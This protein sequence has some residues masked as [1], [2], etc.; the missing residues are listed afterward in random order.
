MCD[1]FAASNYRQL[2]VS[3]SRAP[4]S[5]EGYH[6]WHAV[7]GI[8][9]PA[10]L[11]TLALSGPRSTSCGTRTWSLTRRQPIPICLTLLPFQLHVTVLYSTAV[12]ASC[13]ETSL[14]YRGGYD[15]N[16]PSS[17]IVAFQSFLWDCLLSLDLS[18]NVHCDVAYSGLPICW[19]YSNSSCRTC[20]AAKSKCILFQLRIY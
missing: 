6:G 14:R 16:R 9:A 4:L 7:V 2:D 5:F 8:P 17:S 13:S 1:L 12:L 15:G 18:S 3:H 10:F 11:C 19:S 20:Q